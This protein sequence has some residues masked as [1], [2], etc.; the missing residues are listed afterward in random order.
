M[1]K[2]FKLKSKLGQYHVV[3]TPQKTSPEKLPLTVAQILQAPDL[4]KIDSKKENSRLER[5]I[6][7]SR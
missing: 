6:D 3:L 4:E 2:F 5:A 1:K 7:N